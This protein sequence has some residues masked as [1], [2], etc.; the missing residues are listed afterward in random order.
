VSAAVFLQTLY[1]WCMTFA[2]LG[3]FRSLLTRENRTI[4]YV[5]DSAYWLYLAHLPLILGAQII[6]QGWPGPA[7]LKC[8]LLTL[9]ITAF[10]LLVYD[11]AVRY[12][13]LGTLLNGPRTKPGKQ[14]LRVSSGR[15]S[16]GN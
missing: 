15:S 14:H 10:L 3:M 2:C 4:R 7:V 1:A 9:A 11:Q 5:S 13:W 6:V 8:L 12:T 16:Q